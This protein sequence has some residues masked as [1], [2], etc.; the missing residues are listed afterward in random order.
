MADLTETLLACQNPGEYEMQTQNVLPKVGSVFRGSVAARTSLIPLFI[1]QVECYYSDTSRYT[2]LKKSFF[3][4]V[5]FAHGH[6]VF[7]TL[8]LF[9][10]I[11][12]R[13]RFFLPNGLNL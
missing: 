6:H 9:R 2:A 4:C 10:F 13:I 11:N 12:S 7:Q 8:V 3:Y 5:F 1:R